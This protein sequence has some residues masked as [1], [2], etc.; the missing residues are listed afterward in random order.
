MQT[1][2]STCIFCLKQS[3]DYQEQSVGGRLKVLAEFFKTVFDEVHLI[4]NLLYQNSVKN[5]KMAW[6][7]S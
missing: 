5:M 7:V 4:V 1:Y 3:I 2:S 6:N